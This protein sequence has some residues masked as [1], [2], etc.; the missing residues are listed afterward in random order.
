RVLSSHTYDHRIQELI[1]VTSDHFGLK[2]PKPPK[3][4]AENISLEAEI[5][6]NDSRVLSG[7]DVKVSIFASAIRCENWLNFYKSFQRTNRVPFEII[8]VGPRQPDFKLPANFHFVQTNLKPAQCS[9]IAAERSRGE[10]LFQVVDDIE[11]TP[12]AMDQMYDE[13][14]KNKNSM[15]S[16]HYY[17]G[18]E[19]LTLKQNACGEVTTRLPLLPVCGMFSQDLFRKAGGLDRRFEAVYWELDLYMRFH[20]NFQTETH[21]VDS[22]CKEIPKLNYSFRRLSDRAKS[23]RT[24]FDELWSLTTFLEGKEERPTRESFEPYLLT[25][26]MAKQ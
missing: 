5:E 7:A 25:N 11:Y 1:R 2:V 23:D 3:E 21:F 13:A 15:T 10:M 4:K 12:G 18:A 6:N 16:C 8:F 19:D 22:I 17:F 26:I 9:A 20:F 14:V 24:F